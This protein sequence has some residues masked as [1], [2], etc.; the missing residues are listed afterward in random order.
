[1][2]DL[3]NHNELIVLNC[4]IWFYLWFGLMTYKIIKTLG[5][6]TRVLICGWAWNF[7]TFETVQPDFA[8]LGG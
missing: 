2:H 7:K 3:A 6:Y 4:R 5:S 1:M 8:A